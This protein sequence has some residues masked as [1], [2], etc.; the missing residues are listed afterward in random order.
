M[1]S[2]N[3]FLAAD[4]DINSYSC[5][6]KRILKLIL[7]KMT[8]SK[9]LAIYLITFLTK[10]FNAIYSRRIMIMVFQPLSTIFQLYRGGQFY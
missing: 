4:T 3:C 5:L 1:N 6:L 7:L 10:Y 9:F 8:K 2:L